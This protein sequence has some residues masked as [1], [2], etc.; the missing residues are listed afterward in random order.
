MEEFSSY[1]VYYLS[2]EYV[3]RINRVFCFGDGMTCYMYEYTMTTELAI[4]QPVVY[5]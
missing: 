2:Y 3:V 1:F 5:V 4:S